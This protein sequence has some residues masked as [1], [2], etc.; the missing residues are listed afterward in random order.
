MATNIGGLTWMTMRK[1]RR[2]RHGV[3]GSVRRGRR[4]RRSCKPAEDFLNEWVLYDNPA[5]AGRE[6]LSPVA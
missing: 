2:A 6:M 4:P 1:L 5:L 3:T